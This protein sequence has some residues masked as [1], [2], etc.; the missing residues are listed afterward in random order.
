MSA[1][2]VKEDF[3]SST[4]ITVWHY[5]A[6]SVEAGKGNPAGVV[7][8][9]D[10]ISEADMQRIAQAV[11][12]NE[13]VFIG[14]SEIADYR[15]RYFTPGHEINLCGH[16]TVAGVYHLSCNAALDEKSHVSIETKA[17]II[18]AKI[19]KNNGVYIIKMEQAAPE[20]LLFEGDIEKLAA[21]MGI[22]YTDID[23]ELPV[24]YGSTGTWTLLVPIK[25]LEPFSRMKPQNQLFPQILKQN[26]HC[27]VHPFCLSAL[28]PDRNIHSRHFSSPYS[29]TIEDPVTGTASGVIGAYIATYVDKA[30]SEYSFVMEQGQELGRG[31][32]VIVQVSSTKQGLQVSISGTAVF[33]EKRE[34]S[35]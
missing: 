26:P 35:I 12:F 17:G 7:S 33:A 1:P 11:G 30:C 10:S 18:G 22:R 28:A 5:D 14:Q 6:F 8:N 3:M 32:E 24:M 4:N 27:S 19:Q 21:S 9:T 23:N 15:F 34:L 13:T 25:G 31:G 16:G 20:F 29:G 2:T